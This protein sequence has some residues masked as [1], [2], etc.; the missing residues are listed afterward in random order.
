MCQPDWLSLASAQTWLKDF[1][2][3][4]TRA[5][6]GI[7]ISGTWQFFVCTKIYGVL[8]YST[9]GVLPEG[10]WPKENAKMKIKICCCF[11]YRTTALCFS[12][13][14][15]IHYTWMMIQVW[16]VEG[17]KNGTKVCMSVT[18]IMASSLYY[19]SSSSSI[20]GFCPQ[21]SLGQIAIL[22]SLHR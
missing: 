2:R 8:T 14:I 6:V 11:S 16:K 13:C 9:D 17:I 10:C 7:F 12:L 4:V 18:V 1:K 19:P 3:K 5:Y 22:S 20:N 15:K 21:K